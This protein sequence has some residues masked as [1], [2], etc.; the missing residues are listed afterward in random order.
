[1]R[2]FE[3]TGM[4]CAA[5]SAKVENT[6]SKM[7]GVTSCSVN[8]LLGTMVV[9]GTAKSEDII[10]AIDEIGFGASLKE[11][12]G[13]SEK[14]KEDEKVKK[15][16]FKRLISS[17]VLLAILM[18]FSMGGMLNLPQPGDKIAGCVEG[19]IALIIMIINR[20]FFISGVKSIKNKAPN[21][22]AL[23][24]LGS[25]VSFIS[26]AVMLITGNTENGLYFDSAAM[27]LTLVT[28][29]KLLEARAKSK[30]TSAI[31][32]L[33]NLT[34]DKATILV[35]GKEISVDV[36]N[37]KIGDI[38]VIR[39]GDRLPVD[40]KIIFGSGSFDESMLTGESI[41]IDK[42]EKD[43]VSAG[44]ICSDGYITY[45]A[46]KVG[47]DT[48][49]SK[50]IRLVEKAGATKA[51][52]AKTADRVAAVVVP[53]VICLALITFII[54]LAITKDILFSL[55]GGVSVLVISCPCALGLAT[56]VAITVGS[57]TAAKTGILFRSAASLE[58]TGRAT[59]VVMDKTGTIT[60]GFP[61]VDSFCV[62][63]GY[64]EKSL[65]SLAFSIEKMSS[66]PLSKAINAYCRLNNIDGDEAE[67]FSVIPG[68]GIE[69]M[70][71]G[72]KIRGGNINFIDKY[73][74]IPPYINEKIKEYENEGKTVICFGEN[75]KLCG[76]V[77]VADS[78][79]DDS[80]KA[81]SEMKA[82]GLHTVMLTGDNSL[83][84]SVIGKEAGTDE[85]IAD[86]FPDKKA[87]IITS[88][89]EKYK[90]IMIG[91]GINDAPALASADVGMAIGSG[92]DVAI[93]S[94]DVVLVGSNLSCAVDAIKTGRRVLRNIKQN[95]FWAFFYNALGIPL[96]AGVFI[97]LFG[98]E[99]N[100]MICAGA[101][102]LSS[103]CVVS[104]A[105]RLM[106]PGKKRPAKP[107]KK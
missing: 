63:D 94:A 60:E 48:A 78:V 58:E 4:A 72:K 9:E 76:I 65:F 93:D 41:P 28:I 104:N 11:D 95:L 6:V 86:V 1:M 85:I 101:M 92:T 10:D 45:E 26:S 15:G 47:K 43:N 77:A 51:P 23:V 54:R 68:L 39:A 18:Y 44:T 32:A 61:S 42:K 74:D 17:L 71:L 80:A 14:K 91:D 40:G 89:K 33:I 5:C 79:R 50:I 82:M 31:D 53:A 84:A 97:P 83:T 98:I 34:P 87:E 56:P 57:G 107:G 106:K 3:I 21:M 29:G 52:I 100:P 55:R 2:Q 69:G 8:L 27:I 7:K 30:T 36:S 59:A 46:E 67:E 20:R 62:C 37:V 38:V 24:S 35:D 88:L 16:I 70:L 90:V 49:L 103:F 12:T 96:A 25:G 73:A 102:S 99:L 105:L 66:H 81:I 64:D 13:T 19:V 75:D 22:D